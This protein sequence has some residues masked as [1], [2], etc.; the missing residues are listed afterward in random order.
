MAA[1][2]YYNSYNAGRRE[3]APLPPVPPSSTPSPLPSPHP[4]RPHIDTQNLQSYG[5]SYPSAHSVHSVHSHPS[6]HTYH[7]GHSPVGSPFTDQAYPAY[8][9]GTH[10]PTN[11]YGPVHGDDDTAYHGAGSYGQYRPMDNDPFAD[12]SAIPLHAQQPKMDASPSRYNGD[13]EGQ[14]PLVGGPD[15]M[16]RERSRRHKKKSGWFSGKITWVV[17]TLTVVQIAVFIGEIIKNATLTGSPIMIKPS[18]NPMIGPSGYVYIN[19]GARFVPCMRHMGGGNEV[20]ITPDIAFPCPN[21]TTGAA[22]CSLNELCGMSGIPQ[23]DGELRPNQWYR[24]ITPIF[25]HGGLIHIGF[26]ML[27]QMTV[28]R[29]VE[30]LIGSIRFFL[31]YFAAGIFG[32]ILGANYAPNAMPSVGA[33]GAIFGLIAI[34][35]LDL[36]YHWKERVSPKKE[37]LFIMLDVVIAFVLGLLPGLDNFAHIGGFIMGIGLGISILHSPQLLRE[38]TGMDEPP[39]SAVPNQKHDE[40]ESVKN[41]TKQP[42]GF[43]KGRKPLWWAWWLVRAGCIVVVF[44][45]FIVLLN[46]FYSSH[47]ECK[48]CKY[49]NCIP[50]SDWCDSNTLTVEKTNTTSKRDL[51]GLERYALPDFDSPMPMY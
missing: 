1:N 3:D 37:L 48:W 5:N 21:S 26:N 12:G 45:A 24:F 43:F 14:A 25:L 38:R 8:P 30:L 11:P 6:A 47:S 16:R 28:G 18:F 9:Q 40:F 29:D 15:G 46:N 41:F 49:L 13:P 51:F 50:V 19:M 7:T 44:V 2:D 34:T 39:Y 22:E 4:T 17:F 32:N 36:L 20:D 27:V 10:P 35:L 33:S 42:V 31:V 23:S